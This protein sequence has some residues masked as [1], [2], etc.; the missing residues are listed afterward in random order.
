M[1]FLND[2]ED[3]CLFQRSVVK[4]TNFRIS[5]SPNFWEGYSTKF[6]FKLDVIIVRDCCSLRSQR[7]LGGEVQSKF[8]AE[9]SCARF[10][11]SVGFS[12]RTLANP[13]ETTK[14]DYCR[15][16]NLRLRRERDSNPRYGYP[17]YRLSRSALSTTQT[18]L[19]VEK[20]KGRYSTTQKQ[21]FF[22]LLVVV[23]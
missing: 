1:I 23:S 4:G 8:K 16:L 2:L 18:P 20:C 22:S 6:S 3:F 14:P 9:P 21:M 7:S 17:V 13:P 10:V 19:R 15:A 11:V 12:Q 5:T